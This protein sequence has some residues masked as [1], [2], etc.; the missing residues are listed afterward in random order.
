[1]RIKATIVCLVAVGSLLGYNFAQA[2][3]L[4]LPEQQ[5]NKE[6][7]QLE[8]IEVTA[9]KRTENLQ[10]VPASITAFTENQIEDADIHSMADVARETPNLQWFEYGTR[11]H[12]FFSIRGIVSQPSQEPGMGFYVDDVA[13]LEGMSFNY[14]LFDIE[15]IEVL[16][17]PQGTLYGRNTLGGAINIISRK[18]DNDYKGEVTLEYGNYDHVNVNAGLRG[19]IVADKLFLGISG[20]SETRDGFYYN[21]FLGHEDSGRDGKGLRGGMEWI[22]NDRLDMSLTIQGQKH[23]DSAYI[24]GS[25]GVDQPFHYRHDVE[26]TH[27]SDMWSSTLRLKYNADL[28]KLTSITGW[29]ELDVDEG[30]YDSDLTPEDMHTGAYERY[31]N[32]FTQELRIASPNED[33]SLKWIAGV[34]YFNKI[35]DRRSVATTG[36]DA[37]NTTIPWDRLQ[38]QPYATG[39]GM[40]LQSCRSVT[41]TGLGKIRFFFTN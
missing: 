20:F 40:D 5:K 8:E 33:K 3:K 18:P 34:Y 36:V 31:V 6:N 16:R 19:P 30:V 21:D 29:R 14:P 4:P 15:R 23:E 41:S 25:T 2:E 12:Q 7:Y 9:E 11:L 22:P 38:G 35:D 28:F 27:K 17:G 37:P 13:Y 39:F 1:M 26:G 24:A 10:K 32:A